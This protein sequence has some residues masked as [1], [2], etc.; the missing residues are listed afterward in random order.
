MSDPRLVFVL[1]PYQNA[2]FFE[3]AEALAAALH[4]NSI[5]AIV[6]TEPQSHDPASGDVFVLLPPHEYVTLEGTAFVDDPQVAART[7]GVSAEQP[8]QRFFSHNAQIAGALAAVFDFS[9]LAVE[10]YRAHGVD[11]D[12]LAFGHVPTWDGFAQTTRDVAV[13]Y[14][15]NQRPRRLSVLA[16]AA[17]ALVRHDARLLISDSGEPNRST[18][19]AFVAGEHKRTLLGRTELV[20]NIHQSDEPYFEWLRM[21]DAAHGEAAF[22]SEPS[23]ADEP[24]VAG[25][26]YLTF[27]TDT[28]GTRLDELVG[29]ARAADV[30]RRAHELVASMPLTD[31]VAPLISCAGHIV[32]TSPVPTAL[33]PRVRSAPIGRLRVDPVPH[34]QW[35][36]GTIDSLRDRAR[37]PIQLLPDGATWRVDP[38]DVINRFAGYEAV[39]VG[40]SGRDAGGQPTLEGLWPWEPWRLIHGQHLGRVM[41]VAPSLYRAARRWLGGEPWADVLPHLA[42]QVFAAAHGLEL[43]HWSAPIVDLGDTPA[44]PDAQLEPAVAG[45]VATI[46]QP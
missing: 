43:T 1:S 35:S 19:P 36:P 27:E 20:V 40:A 7:V 6:V 33:P 25:E 31:T 45:R 34:A 32:A 26:H 15:G 37:R 39:A 28:L 14:F 11:A 3:I 44:D 8:H 41:C 46:L 12:R 18:S 4:A 22:V 13:L 10:A 42:V 5:D 17:D 16:G 9:Q 38:G 2:F 30:A 29:D 21:I 24:F 23:V